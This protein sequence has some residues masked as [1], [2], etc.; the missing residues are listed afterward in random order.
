[1]AA[2]AFDGD[3]LAFAGEAVG[4]DGGGVEAA[5]RDAGVVQRLCDGGGVGAD[6]PFAAVDEEGHLAFGADVQFQP[7]PP[8]G[9][10]AGG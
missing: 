1:M 2:D 8:D 10:A 3:R 7:V 9:L 5:Q 4:V 6:G